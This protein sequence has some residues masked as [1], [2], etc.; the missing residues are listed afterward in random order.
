MN[1]AKDREQIQQEI[2]D[3]EQRFRKSRQYRDQPKE[4][5]EVEFA[6]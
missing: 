2:A 6:D 5:P 1:R 4:Q 3:M